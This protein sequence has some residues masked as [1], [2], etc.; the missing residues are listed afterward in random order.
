M[1]NLQYE[2][3]ICQKSLHKVTRTVYFYGSDVRM[4]LYLA[5]RLTSQGISSIVV[6]MIF[7]RMF[8]LFTSAQFTSLFG[9]RQKL[10]EQKYQH[11]DRFSF[12]FINIHGFG[13]NVDIFQFINDCSNIADLFA[14]GPSIYYLSI[15]LGIFYPLPLWKHK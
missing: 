14:K 15:F 1:R 9:M 8:F 12:N 5:T 7:F 6:I 4:N 13:G 3:R 11:M 2:M 10:H